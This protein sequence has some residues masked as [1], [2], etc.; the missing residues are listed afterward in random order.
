MIEESA[1]EAVKQASD[2]KP[3]VF[4]GPVTVQVVFTDPSYADALEYLDLVTR[5]DGRM[6]RMEAADLLKAF[7]QFNALHFLA[8]VV[9]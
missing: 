2:F 3:F 6:I 1:A 4:D 9:R 5:I 7:E 8:P